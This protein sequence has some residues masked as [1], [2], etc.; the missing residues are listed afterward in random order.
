MRSALRA[1]MNLQIT[2]TQHLPL[3]P[4]GSKAANRSAAEWILKRDGS[5]LLVLKA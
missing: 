4:S 1:M 3:M 5:H 2:Q